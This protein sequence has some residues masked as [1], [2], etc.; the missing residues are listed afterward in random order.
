MKKNFLL[1]PILAFIICF[2]SCSK[3]NPTTPT[4]ASVMFVNGCAGTGNVDVSVNGTKLVAASNLAFL[5]TSGYQ[6][7]TA[8]TSVDFAFALT[9]TGT[10]LISGSENIT[11]GLSYSVFTGGL[12]TGTST[13]FIGTTDDLTAPAAGMA[14]VRFANLSSDNLNLNCYIGTPKIDSNVSMGTITPF[15]SISATTTGVNVLLQDPTKPTELSELSSQNFVA[16]KIYTIMLTGTS[17]GTLA[18]GLTLTV[19]NNN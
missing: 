13:S 16:G 4:T 5:K 6:T 9:A 14:K 3:N 15:F 19:I 1:F 12:V 8:G 18:S 17:T 10:P 2:T 11:A 7:V